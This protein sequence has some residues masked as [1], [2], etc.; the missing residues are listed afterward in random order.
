MPAPKSAR[1]GVDDR[2]LGDGLMTM[3]AAAPATPERRSTDIRPAKGWASLNLAELWRAR[4]LLYYLVLRELKLRYK[5]AAI[6]VGWAIIQPIF[7]VL[8]FTLIFGHFAKMPTGGTPYAL[9]AFCAVLPWTYFA[10]AVRRSSMGLVSDAE[11]IRKVYFPRLIVPLA[12]VTTPLADFAAGLVVLMGLF[13]W[14]GVA[15][16]P[17]IV[18]LPVFLLVAFGLALSIGLWLGPLSVRYRDVIHTLPFL[19]QVWL[20]ASPVA[21]PI[22]IVPERW[23]LLYSLNPM[24][25]VIEGF[26][27]ALLGAAQPD[28]RAMAISVG[29]IAVSLALGLLYFRRM[30]RSFADVI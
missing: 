4:E 27:W 6:G 26:R 24:V 5:Q 16:T 29:V 17:Y 1:C 25:G 18:L 23:R 11:L 22:T 12:M 7:A 13:A 2:P 20:Y 30:E 10:E 3:D 19:V 8:I 28:F 14:Y 21:Y 9:F 15:P